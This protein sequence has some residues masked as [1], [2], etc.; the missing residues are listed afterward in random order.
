[1]K[2]GLPSQR[3]SGQSSPRT[4]PP[5]RW[6]TGRPQIR[7]IQA[8]M[9]LVVDF[10]LVPAITVFRDEARA[11]CSR[12]AAALKTGRPRSTAAVHSGFSAPTRPPAMTASVSGG[13]LD[14]DHVSEIGIP[15]ARIRSGIGENCRSS[16]PVTATP[17]RRSAMAS[18]P[19]K[20]PQIPR[21]WTRRG[22]GEAFGSTVGTLLTSADSLFPQA[23]SP[24]TS[25]FVDP[26]FSGSLKKVLT[27][28]RKNR[29][30]PTGD[31]NVSDQLNQDKPP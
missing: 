17:R 25:L 21:T 1:M 14:A 10:P 5:I 3:S 28:K 16:V 19:A 18:P 13:R 9:A 11:N 7:K 8:S 12:N 20:R 4:A 22:R 24:F 29:I 2:S 30:L 15:A 6:S 27:I 26:D 31:D 23:P